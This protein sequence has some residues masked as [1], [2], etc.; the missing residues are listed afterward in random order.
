L[1]FVPGVLFATANLEDQQKDNIVVNNDLNQDADTLMNSDLNLEDGA[2][3]EWRGWGRG[4]WGGWGRGGWGGW[5]RG[6][7]GGWGGG[8][9][10]WGGWG[11][12]P[13]YGYSWYPWTWYSGWYW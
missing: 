8:W 4:G 13:Y 3:D 9:G 1:F 10:G 6:G 5:G 7:W 2:S 11:G 12:Y